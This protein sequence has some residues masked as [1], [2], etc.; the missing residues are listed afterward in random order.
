MS[1]RSHSPSDDEGP[2]RKKLKTEAPLVPSR[3]GST[4]LIDSQDTSIFESQTTTAFDSQGT[5]ATAES[6]P[7]KS[8]PKA[9]RGS[10]LKS[11]TTSDAVE[12]KTPARGVR[13]RKSAASVVET[14]DDDVG[15]PTPKKRGG[16]KKAEVPEVSTPER[17]T[18]AW[19]VGAHVSMAGGI[20]NAISNASKI[21]WVLLHS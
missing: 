17:V 1:A 2:A 21:G 3:M 16:R 8:L 6:S 11:A 4:I 15:T 10:L 5:D 20:Q 14:G 9:A 7:A 18:T 19:K 12:K 13:G